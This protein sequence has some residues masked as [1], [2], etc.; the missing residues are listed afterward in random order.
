MLDDQVDHLGVGALSSVFRS[1]ILDALPSIRGPRLDPPVRDAAAPAG[2]HFGALDF[3]EGARQKRSHGGAAR[4]SVT[5][6][7]L[8]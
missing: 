1:S 2:S 8:F 4:P 6:V 3:R 5:G 7:E